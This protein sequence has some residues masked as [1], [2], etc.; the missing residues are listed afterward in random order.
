MSPVKIELLKALETAPDNV[1]EQT[2]QYLKS[3]LPENSQ[4]TEFQPQTP[5][6]KTECVNK[7]ETQKG[8]N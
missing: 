3:L 6:V 7:N 2:L 8:K 5:L 4:V 1:L